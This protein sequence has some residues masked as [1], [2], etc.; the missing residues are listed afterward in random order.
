M[1]R[2]VVQSVSLDS[3]L[4]ANVTQIPRGLRKLSGYQV[5]HRQNRNKNVSICLFSLLGLNEIVT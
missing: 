1:L 5:P 3:G 2:E 4:H